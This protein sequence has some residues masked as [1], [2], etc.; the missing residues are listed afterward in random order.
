ME[1]LVA[2]GAFA[3]L[4]AIAI[5]T[6]KAQVQKAKVAAATADILTIAAAVNHYASLNGVLPPDLATVGMNTKLDPWGHPY[7]YL[8]FVGLHG[9]AQMR[10]DRNLVPINTQF[11]LYSAGADGATVPPITAQQSRDDVIMANDG[12]FVGL[13]STY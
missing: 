7:T 2:M 11:D 5:P 4:S 12:N 10:K 3:L 8:S 9:N 13:A 6:Y 1:L